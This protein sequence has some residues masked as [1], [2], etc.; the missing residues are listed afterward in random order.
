MAN[1]WDFSRSMS[2]R[3]V[4]LPGSFTGVRK[5]RV[6]D[7]CGISLFACLFFIVHLNLEQPVIDFSMFYRKGNHMRYLKWTFRL[8]PAYLLLHIIHIVHNILSNPYLK[9]EWE[10]LTWWGSSL[11]VFGH[12]LFNPLDAFIFI[13]PPAL[14]SAILG[15]EAWGYFRKKESAE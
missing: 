13:V 6:T 15:V 7:F 5:H 2:A 10:G 14:F 11:K 1:T 3:V 4:S 12:I 8:L 9:L